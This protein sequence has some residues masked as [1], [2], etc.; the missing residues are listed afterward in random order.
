MGPPIIKK[1]DFMVL[2][3]SAVCAQ[4]W[5]FAE[6]S[7]LSRLKSLEDFFIMQQGIFKDSVLDV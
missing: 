7:L 3:R 1:P 4:G 6:D 2:M 5:W